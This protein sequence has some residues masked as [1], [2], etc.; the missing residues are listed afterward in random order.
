MKIALVANTSWYLY[1]FRRN[2]MSA[3]NDAG[4]EIISIGSPDGFEFR[5]DDE[6]FAQ[7]TVD[8]HQVGVNPLKEAQTVLALRRLIIEEEVDVVLSWTPKGNIY[9][10]I[11]LLGLHKPLI[12]NVS[13]LGRAF[14]H[15]SWITLVVKRLLK[16]ALRR[17]KIVF[18]QNSDDFRQFVAQGLVDETRSRLLPGSGVDLSHFQPRDHRAPDGN[19]RVLMIS[20]LLW[21]KGIQEFVDAARFLRK[22]DLS[23]QFQLLGAMDQSASSGV[24]QDQLQSWLSEGLVEYLGTTDDVREAIAAADCVV[25]PSYREGLPR[26]LLE[27]SA[28][29]RPV[30]TTD[31]PGCRDCVDEGVNGFLF[32]VQSSEELVRA[33]NEFKQLTTSQRSQMGQAGRQKMEAHFD[34][35]IVIDSYLTAIQAVQ[36]QK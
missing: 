17:A 14:I 11:A 15:K 36:D 26:S 6:G 19:I 30:L 12:A 23:W 32:D 5:L 20:R 9:T 2:L 31:V 1:N 16:F 13:G 27:A 7:R 4:Y 25:L 28:M 21:S 35:R 33:L 10:S 29:A 24:T 8:F 18:F 3:L 22:D 34:E